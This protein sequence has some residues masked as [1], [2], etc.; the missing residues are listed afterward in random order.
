MLGKDLPSIAGSACAGAVFA[1]A[2]PDEDEIEPPDVEAPVDATGA[3]ALPLAE[4]VPASG[5]D[6]V[7]LLLAA[8]ALMLAGGALAGAETLGAGTAMLPAK[9]SAADDRSN[10]NA[11][12]RN[13]LFI[14]TPPNTLI[15]FF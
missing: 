11:A 5:D 9:A 4:D 2:V 8:G 10:T 14:I 1:A 12:K 7:M 15:I 3:G 6:D 13:I